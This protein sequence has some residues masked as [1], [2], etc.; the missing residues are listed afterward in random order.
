M[1]S[2]QDMNRTVIKTVLGDV[3]KEINLDFTIIININIKIKINIK[4]NNLAIW[5]RLTQNQE[6]CVR[7]QNTYFITQV[8][9]NQIPVCKCRQKP[10]Y[11]SGG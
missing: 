9:G 3:R 6:N 11:S 2:I 4:N 5:I 8:A 7:K 10:R 1:H